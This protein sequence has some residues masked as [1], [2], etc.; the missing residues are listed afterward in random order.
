MSNVLE[1][2]YRKA[3]QVC[4]LNTAY[5]HSAS[6]VARLTRRR[7]YRHNKVSCSGYNKVNISD[8]NQNIEKC[9]ILYH[10]L[11]RLVY[12]KQNDKSTF[13]SAS[14][15]KQSFSYS[16][17]ERHNVYNFRLSFIRRKPPNKELKDVRP[18]FFLWNT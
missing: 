8:H 10:I 6:L 3:R 12:L 4:L 1:I 11:C 9:A 5:I 13:N 7:G 15:L 2:S 17:Q 18:C 14:F 16:Y